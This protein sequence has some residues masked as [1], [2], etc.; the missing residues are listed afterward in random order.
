M[1]K[2]IDTYNFQEGPTPKEI[3][4]MRREIMDFH[5]SYGKPYVFKHRWNLDDLS[6]GLCIECPYHDGAYERSKTDCESC[7]GTGFFG[8]F[9]DGVIV[10]CTIAD[11]PVDQLKISPQGYLMFDKHPQLTAPWQPHM[12][13]GDLLID[14]E[15]DRSTWDILST[16]DVFELNDVTPVTIRGLFGPWTDY[17]LYNLQ[18]TANIDRIPNRHI[19][20]EVPIVFD[21]TTVPVVIP[22]TG[23]PDDNKTPYDYAEYSVGFRIRGKEGGL[24]AFSATPFKIFG[25]GTNAQATQGLKITG[26]ELPV[27]IT[28]GD[29]TND[30]DVSVGF[31]VLA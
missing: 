27:V 19:Y 14:A 20:Y 12:G 13:D 30:Y 24:S 9:A 5:L 17:K 6:K 1:A 26:Q 21:T 22:Q 11:A 29:T 4:R 18:Q 15:F 16:G 2:I 3:S 10:F 7:F 31:R 23:T 28:F 8:G 25:D